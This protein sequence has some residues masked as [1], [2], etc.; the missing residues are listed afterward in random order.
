[1]NSADA[2][3]EVLLIGGRSG[4][5]KTSV[6]FEVSELLQGADVAHCLIDGDN[7]DAAYPKAPDDPHGTTI[8]ET[9]LRAMWATYRR[10]GH[11]RLVYVNTSSVLQ[12]AMVTRAM[13]AHAHPRGVLLTASEATVRTRLSSREIGSTLQ[14]HLSRS[15]AA[16]VRLDAEAPEWTVRVATDGR[17]VTEIAELVLATTPWLPSG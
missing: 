7:L 6:G 3:D 4:V 17:T 2:P 15:A 9:N 13:G 11:H 12:A 5:G 10:I 14:R 8:T 1:V 16:A